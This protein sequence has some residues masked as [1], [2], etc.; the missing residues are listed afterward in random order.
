MSLSSVE[1]AAPHRLFPTLN[2]VHGLRSAAVIGTRYGASLQICA[3]ADEIWINK[4]RRTNTAGE[5]CCNAFD[6]AGDP[7]GE[8]KGDAARLC[9]RERR[10]D[11][12]LERGDIRRRPILA[13]PA[14][15]QIEPLLLLPAVGGH[16][17]S[18]SNR[19]QIGYS[20][21]Q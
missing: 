20:W 8:D 5:W 10:D 17:V 3:S 21:Q 2:A 6:C 11:P 12:A 4:E 16:S 7:R 13:V 1:N 9:A 14:P 19:R 15:R 18:A